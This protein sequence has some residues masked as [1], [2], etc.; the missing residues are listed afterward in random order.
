MNTDRLI[1][2]I[3]PHVDAIRIDHM[4]E[5]GRALPLYEAAGCVEAARPAFARETIKRLVE[6][7]TSAGVAVDARDDLASLVLTKLRARGDAALAL[8]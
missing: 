2:E 6:G 4:H 1:A 8:R 5:V 7:F 3:A